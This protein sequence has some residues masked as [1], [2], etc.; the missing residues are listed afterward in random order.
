MIE[1]SGAISDEV[2]AKCEQSMGKVWAKYGQSMGK[3]C[4]SMW[5]F[6]VEV[7]GRMWKYV[8]AIA[9]IAPT[10][11]HSVYRPR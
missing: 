11:Q 10:Q 2:W 3:V 5:K 9:S 7:C 6:V 1:F 4:G 8:E